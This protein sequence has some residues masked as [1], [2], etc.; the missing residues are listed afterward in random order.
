MSEIVAVTIMLGGLV[1]FVHFIAHLVRK[2][3]EQYQFRLKQYRAKKYY[4]KH[5]MITDKADMINMIM[6]KS[7]LSWEQSL[8]LYEQLN[9]K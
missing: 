5:C 8:T 6:I 2:S 7:G 9:K 1:L 3:Q 4:Y